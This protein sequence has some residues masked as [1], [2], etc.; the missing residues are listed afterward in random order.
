M[1]TEI[2]HSEYKGG[3]LIYNFKYS[4]HDLPFI[5][6]KQVNF[7]NCV[8]YALHIAIDCALHI[9]IADILLTL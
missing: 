5:S 3:K 7:E 1:F 9:A 2:A 8:H 4:Q 6:R